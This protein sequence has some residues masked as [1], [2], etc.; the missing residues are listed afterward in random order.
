MGIRAKR[1]VKP[2]INHCDNYV[3]YGQIVIRTRLQKLLA[4]HWLI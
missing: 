3:A 1:M 2:Y 4:K